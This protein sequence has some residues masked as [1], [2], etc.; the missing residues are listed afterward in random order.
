MASAKE[1]TGGTGDVNPQLLTAIVTQTAADTATEL[2]IPIPKAN[3][4]VQK[5]KVILLE[6]LDVKYWF[7]NIVGVSANMSARILLSGEA[8]ATQAHES[9]VF[10]YYELDGVFVTA[11]GFSWTR[12]GPWVD[13]LNDGAGHGVL[14]KGDTIYLSVHSTATGQINSGSIKLKYRWKQVTLEEVFNIR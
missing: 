5:G 12:R 13:I 4:P 14:F 7:S 3:L 8:G 1:L 2:E 6:V 11:A 9:D 10:S